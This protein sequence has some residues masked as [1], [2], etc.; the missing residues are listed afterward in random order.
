MDLENINMS[1]LLDKIKEFESGLNFKSF[2]RSSRELANWL[3]SDYRIF[4]CTEKA[5]DLLSKQTIFLNRTFVIDEE[6]LFPYVKNSLIAMSIVEEK[7]AHEIC[8]MMF[9]SFNFDIDRID[10][11]AI[12]DYELLV[13]D[14]DYLLNPMDF[15]DWDDDI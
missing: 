7:E 12:I 10:K 11:S 13:T 4:I 15:Y 1:F 9:F 6:I 2:C 8:G 14:D 5:Y 3:S